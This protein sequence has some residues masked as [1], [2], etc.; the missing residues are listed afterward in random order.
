M[1]VRSPTVLTFHRFFA[2]FRQNPAR[3]TIVCRAR[4]GRA[5]NLCQRPHRG[6]P[7]IDSKQEDARQVAHE[8]K[9]R[10]LSL[11]SVYLMHGPFPLLAC[12]VPAASSPAVAC[13][14]PS[15][16]LFWT[17]EWGMQ[18]KKAIPPAMNP[19]QTSGKCLVSEKRGTSSYIQL[20]R[21]NHNLPGRIGIGLKFRAELDAKWLF[22]SAPFL[23]ADRI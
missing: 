1:L 18:S 11:L 9:G 5:H 16:W 22:L 10:S 3:A 12:R 21:Q 6:K 19:Q 14:F 13:L 17:F 4:R 23:Q 15:L 20:E 8:T 7:C 2:R